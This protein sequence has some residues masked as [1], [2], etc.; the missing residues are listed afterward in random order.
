MKKVEGANTPFSIATDPEVLI[1]MEQSTK[2]TAG[3]AFP[4]FAWPLT[5]GGKLEIA[6]MPGW[7]V[8]V[9]YRG[10]HCPR[11]K[12]YLGTLDGLLD[13]FK[14][15][16]IA[17]AAVSADPAE[18]AQAS[19]AENGWRFPVAY[20]LTIPQMKALGLYISD[21]RSPQETDRPFA[22]P[23]LFVINPDNNAQVVDIANAAYARPDLATL[24]GGIKYVI[25]N[26]LPVR[27]T[28]A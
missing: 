23:G 25:D 9:V 28:H 15:A 2:F 16:G 22:E 7:R 10:K 11:C 3:T 24:L 6:G 17:V 12:T 19:V 20:D 5:G 8:L 18:K 4:A 27:G 1:V 14:A 26:K 21:P 13:D